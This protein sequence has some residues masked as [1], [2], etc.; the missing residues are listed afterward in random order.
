MRKK[1]IF[2]AYAYDA[3]MSAGVNIASKEK[4]K[5]TYL[6]NATVAL[7]SAKKSNC[8]CDV[9]IVTNIDIPNQY[10]EIYK[11][12]DIIIY[13]Q[14]FDSFSFGA[15]YKWGLAFYKLCALKNMLNKEYDKFLLLDTDVYVQSSLDDLWEETIHNIMLYDVNHRLTNHDCNQFNLEVKSFL[16]EERALTNYGGEFIAGNLQ[17]L[18]YFVDECE[19]I[20]ERMMAQKFETNFGDEFIIRIVADYMR[21]NVKNSAA[22]VY[23]FWT[24]SFYL[25]STCYSANPV[26]VLHVPAEKERGMLKLF[27]YFYKHRIFPANRRIYRILGLSHQPIRSK[28]QKYLI[29]LRR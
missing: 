18:A 27:K 25:V 24:G 20:Y 16:G 22:Y 11:Y 3:N 12:N 2:C 9:A 10:K 17:Q 15:N 26:S 19:K 23:R 14:E 5:S 4:A 6:E 1:I 13:K 29:A 7:V 8:N 21:A 28:L